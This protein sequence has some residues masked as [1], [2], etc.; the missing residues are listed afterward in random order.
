[1]LKLWIG[2]CLA[3]VTGMGG[4]VVGAVGENG[5][6]ATIGK[7]V[8]MRWDQGF[9]VSRGAKGF[10]VLESGT[11]LTAS[12]IVD[13]SGSRVE[14]WMSPDEGKTWQRP[15]VITTAGS[16]IDLGDGHLIELDNGDILYS[17][18]RN[19]FAGRYA[20][21]KKYAI[22]VAVSHDKGATWNDHSVVARSTPAT[23]AGPSRG[24]W[25]SFLL[26]KSD[27][28]LQ[29]YF[30]DEDTPNRKGYAGHQWVT[31]CTW[32]REHRRWV[33]PVTVSR[34]HRKADLSRDGMP[35][36]VE[37][38]DGR[39]LAVVETVGAQ[40]PHP[41]IVMS[42]TSSDGG[43][44]WSWKQGPRELVYRA[45]SN[46]MALSPWLAKIDANRLICV[47]VTDED[48]DQADMSGT[49]AD[50]LNA[51]VKYVTSVDAGEVWSRPH[52]LH[53]RTH[54][55]YKPGVARLQSDQ[56]GEA[57]LLVMLLDFHSNKYL[58]V[59]GEVVGGR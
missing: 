33:D 24:L 38:D 14:C 1:M 54:R 8:E 3:A 42:V 19:Q 12:T 22:E 11:V 20:Q 30:D 45:D 40:A 36:V 37:L 48:R 52:D 26:E 4:V 58:S 5:S 59:R 10:V 50:K 35:S 44:T 31:M 28:T 16:G 27:G 23:Q 41:N 13:S 6:G 34:A 2:I 21:T 32:N 18:R 39:L 29:C 47:F 57:F 49:P 15:A 46:H 53:T 9:S 56:D 55:T 7:S 43:R 17:Y 51:D 25:A